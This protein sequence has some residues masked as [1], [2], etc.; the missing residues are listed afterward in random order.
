MTTHSK[1]PTLLERIA[2]SQGH[3]THSARVSPELLK[4]VVQHLPPSLHALMAQ[5]TPAIKALGDLSVFSSN[6]RHCSVWAIGSLLHE[7]T[8]TVERDCANV[9]MT[10]T[11]FHM[12]LTYSMLHGA[13]GR[14]AWTRSMPTHEF[15]FVMLMP[16]RNLAFSSIVEVTLDGVESYLNGGPPP[17]MSLTGVASRTGRTTWKRSFEPQTRSDLLS[18]SYSGF[19]SIEGFLWDHQHGTQLL[20][21]DRTATDSTLKLPAPASLD[22]YSLQLEAVD[23][24]SGHGRVVGARR[25]TQSA[26]E[27]FTT[28]SLDQGR[29]DDI[30]LVVPDP[31]VASAALGQS[32]GQIVAVDYPT[33]AT[34]W[35]S[36]DL[37]ISNFFVVF[38]TASS[39]RA[40][41]IYF[42]FKRTSLLPQLEQAGVPVTVGPTKEFAESS[43]LSGATGRL[44]WT[45][46]GDF[47]G[48]VSS[49]ISLVFDAGDDFQ[50][51][52]LPAHFY[53]IDEHGATVWTRSVTMSAA[54]AESSYGYGGAGD[55]QPDGLGDGWFIRVDSAADQFDF[56][57]G[58]IFDGHDGHDVRTGNIGSPLG[59][60]LDGHGDDLLRFQGSSTKPVISALDGSTGRA[61]WTSRYKRPLVNFWLVYPAYLIDRKPVFFTVYGTTENHFVVRILEAHSGALQH[62]WSI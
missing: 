60:S 6:T 16:Q 42:H 41:L 62:Q 14:V 20:L 51:P 59:L 32:P 49:R 57:H 33:G 48:D 4:T 15:D 55:V 58:N 22:S 17:T 12:D 45:H 5:R 21:S 29:D 23:P 9:Y 34:R 3:A 36:A 24:M 35:K 10:S 7:A 28:S 47:V 11:S 19:E 2:S 13:N 25:D 37:D 52:A 40:P 30:A 31:T 54:S 46:R 27:V 56:A 53:A 1:E 44:Q 38:S 61:F 8:T 39:P 18:K 26:V 50:S 43:R